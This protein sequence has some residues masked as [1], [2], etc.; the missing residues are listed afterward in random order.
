MP[1]TRLHIEPERID[2]LPLALGIL[3]HMGVPQIVNAHLGPGHGNRQGLSY[4][5]LAHG[6]S[7][8]IIAAQDHRLVTVEAWSREHQRVLSSLLGAPVG[9]KDFTDDRLADLL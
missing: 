1:E 7:A 6:L 8:H 3:Q 5:Q 4:G 9:D 2:E